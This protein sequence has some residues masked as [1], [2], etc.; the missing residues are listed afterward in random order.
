[1][2]CLYVFVLLFHLITVGGGEPG[3]PKESSSELSLFGV[4]IVSGSWVTSGITSA[5]L[6]QEDSEVSVCLKRLR[7]F[8]FW[9]RLSSLL[10]DLLLPIARMWER[11]TRTCARRGL[12]VAHVFF[13]VLS[14]NHHSASLIVCR[15]LLSV[16]LQVDFAS[17]CVCVCVSSVCQ[18]S[19]SSDG[20]F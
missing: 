11:S 15:V 16:N 18:P 14:V 19:S 6:V 8:S 12:N 10:A 13:G 2:Y 17:V 5:G 20:V 1:M 3:D 9:S 7:F 4:L